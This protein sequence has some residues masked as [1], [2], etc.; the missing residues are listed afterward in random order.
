[1]YELAD[2]TRL[3]LQQ[4]PIETEGLTSTVRDSA[5]VLSPRR[6]TSRH[7]TAPTRGTSYPSEDRPVPLANSCRANALGCPV[8][9]QA[10][11]R[12][13]D[14]VVAGVRAVELGAGCGLS[15]LVLA[16]R[17]AH[18]VLSD[19]GP[20]LALLETNCRANAHAWRR[21]RAPTTC[22]LA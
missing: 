16:A 1:M 3:T 12:L 8:A 4:R 22:A 11:E 19:L 7:S 6:G 18:V 9:A 14:S 5:I 17:G 15:G 13:E 2:G 10:L 21:P 20:N